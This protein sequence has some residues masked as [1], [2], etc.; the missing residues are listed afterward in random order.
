MEKLRVACVQWGHRDFSDAADYWQEL[1]WQIRTA[2]FDYSAQLLILP[3]YVAAGFPHGW[4]EEAE[5]LSRLS[6]LASELQMWMV[7]G[8]MPRWAENGLRNRA[9]ILGPA[10]EQFFQ[11]KLHITPWE[12]DAWNMVGGDG[13]ALIDIGGC[14]IAVAICYDVEF[15]EQIRAV[16]DVGA[17]ILCV[18]YCTDDWH[19]HHRVTR[20]AMAR[21]VENTMYIATAG[22]VG[23]IRARDGFAHHQAQSMIATP[24]DIG[25]PFEGVAARANA[26]QPGV[27]VAELDLAL[28]RSRRQ[29]GTVQPRE[30]LRRDLFPV[31]NSAGWTQ[32]NC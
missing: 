18:P 27:I 31:S 30:N 17:E 23:M 32:K 19:G 24:C 21:A 8:S 16:A 15:P 9:W 3:E 10:G 13:L 7:A 20:C 12:R 1:E 5:W 22:G 14:K 26:D 11:D 4:P 6:L 28:L 25:F 29:G 2:R